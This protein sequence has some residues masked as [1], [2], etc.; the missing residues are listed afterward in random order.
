V[1][2]QSAAQAHRGKDEGCRASALL[3]VVK[4][5]VKK[6]K[7]EEEESEEQEKSRGPRPLSSVA[8]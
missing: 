5:K 1:A 6:K 4:G 3:K 7:K 8:S 2:H